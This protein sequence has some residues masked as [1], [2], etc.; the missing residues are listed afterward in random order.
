MSLSAEV[1]GLKAWIAGCEAGDASALLLLMSHSRGYRRIFSP[2][3]KLD[4]ASLHSSASLSSTK[5]TDSV[6]HALLHSL[7]ESVVQEFESLRAHHEYKQQLALRWFPGNRH[8]TLMDQRLLRWR[9]LPELEMWEEHQFGGRG[10]N[11]LNSPDHAGASDKRRPCDDF[12]KFWHCT[13]D[14]GAILFCRR[15]KTRT[16]HLHNVSQA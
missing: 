15:T 13:S 5:R 10:A 9:P 12:R 8:W 1:T 3:E 2:F 14:G 16:P 7:N 4:C 6:E 11:L